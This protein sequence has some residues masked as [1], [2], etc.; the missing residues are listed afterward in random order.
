MSAQP[1]RLRVVDCHNPECEHV[2][3]EASVMRDMLDSQKDAI[4]QQ[5]NELER[6]RDGG[7]DLRNAER[8]IRRLRRINTKLHNELADKRR[9]DPSYELALSIFEYWKRETGRTDRTK[10]TEDREKA[11]LKAL[12]N[13]T[14]RYLALAILGAKYAASTGDNG[15]RYD[16][17]ELIA[18]GAKPESFVARYQAW[19]VRQ[20]LQPVPEELPDA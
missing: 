6:L 12:Q 2:R 16:D 7:E 10:F 5:A 3:L 8:E 11:V 15:V 17:L 13:Y 9:M 19:R 20:G 1:A 14:P 18:R 4:E